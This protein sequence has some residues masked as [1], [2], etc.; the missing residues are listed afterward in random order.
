M[1]RASDVTNLAMRLAGYS[2]AG[3][4]FCLKLPVIGEVDGD[5]LNERRAAAS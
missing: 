4:P 2:T 5:L 3:F 1:W